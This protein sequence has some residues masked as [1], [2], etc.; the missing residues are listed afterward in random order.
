MTWLSRLM[1]VA[2]LACAANAGAQVP[3]P[4]PADFRVQIWGFA[5]VDFNTRMSG[6]AALRST[7]QRGLAVLMVTDDPRD[8]LRAERVLARRIRHARAGANGG[9]I[10][11]PE[12]VA[13]F[14]GILRLETR[15]STCAGLMDDNPG[16]IS[17]RIN[18][19]YPKR[20]PLSTVPPTILNRLPGLPDDVQYRFLGE[21]LI[22]HDTRA[23]VILDR[24]A[25]AIECK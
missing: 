25:N 5:A 8:I 21:H 2:A 12:I 15:A 10:F 22:L 18:G 14:K 24:I 3:T 7:L 11:T 19:T 23:N 1:V 13:A 17:Y 16:A 20:E 4:D 9:E 6:Y